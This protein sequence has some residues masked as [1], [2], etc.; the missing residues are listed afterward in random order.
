MEKLLKII[1]VFFGTVWVLVLLFFH[2]GIAASCDNENGDW[3]IA[4]VLILIWWILSV[5]TYIIYDNLPS[6]K[7]FDG[8]SFVKKPRSS[9]AAIIGKT[10]LNVLWMLALAALHIGI[11][12]AYIIEKGWPIWTGLI[13]VWWAVTIVTH[14][15]KSRRSAKKEAEAKAEYEREYVS[16]VV[17]EDELLG[18]MKFRLD[19]KFNE[20][21]SEE[22]D[23]PPFG[24][25]APAEL[26]VADYRES[27]RERIFR[28]LRGV[29]EHKDE[30][31]ER[32]YPDL[33][34][35]AEEYGETDENG[36]P[37]TLETLREVTAVY[38][39][40]VCNSGELFSVDLELY[41]NKGNSGAWRSRGKRVCRLRRKKDRRR[42][43]VKFFTHLL[44]F[45][46]ICSIIRLCGN[47]TLK[48]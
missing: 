7:V 1:K 11:I 48:C 44:H 8:V 3:F 20:L 19:S 25:S 23:L 22:I 12:G 43:G 46:K 4:A 17:I 45:G 31:M 34:E 13:A 39:L 29:Y 28:A 38:S 37:Y 21:E 9:R 10:A 16:E 30:I 5:G 32:I 27:D 47:T 40:T 14:T 6:A 24:A 33:L 26:L 42:L 36:E 35:I 15:V 18:K 41:R 2:L